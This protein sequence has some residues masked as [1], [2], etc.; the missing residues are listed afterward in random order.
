MARNKFA[1]DKFA[2]NVISDVNLPVYRSVDWLT[3]VK[4]LVFDWVIE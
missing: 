4:T 3:E 2:G 1:T